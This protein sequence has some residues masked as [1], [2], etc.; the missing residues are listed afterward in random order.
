MAIPRPAFPKHNAYLELLDTLSRDLVTDSGPTFV[1]L[2]CGGGGLDLGLSLAGWTGAFAT[3]IVPAYC[4]TVAT[5]LPHTRTLAIDATVLSGDDIRREAGL[6]DGELGLIAGGPPCQPFSILGKRG[7]LNDPRGQLL[8][9]FVRLVAE[10]RPRGFLFENVPG[11]RSTNGGRDWSVFLGRLADETGY[12][13]RDHLLN[14]VYY[15][16]P[17]RRERVFVVGFRQPCSSFV[18][19]QP[20][21][22]EPETLFSDLP[23]VH[24]AFGALESIDGLANH[25]IRPH[26]PR[27]ANRYALLTQGSRDAI[28]HTDRIAPDRPAGTVLVGS[29]AGGGRPHIHPY[30]PRVITVREAARLQTFPDWYAFKGTTTEQYRQV[31]NAVP[32]L[33]AMT[34]GAE[35][36][37]ALYGRF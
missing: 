24:A 22:R 6:E 1:S 23:V 33:M 37:R 13:V 34:I 28:D 19:P 8:Y 29:A 36:R 27:V 16:A 17:Q 7:S 31:G 2:F 30:E 21:F 15:G 14:A 35:L 3:D 4:D 18:F 20:V 10:L 11:I 9:H 5:N 26:G 12:V 32:P 25:Q